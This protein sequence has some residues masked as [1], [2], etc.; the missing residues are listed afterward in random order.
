MAVDESK[1]NV[2]MQNLVHD[3]APSCMSTT[4]KASAFR[5]PKSQAMALA[6]DPFNLI[7]EARP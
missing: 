1:L 2:F 4:P 6:E 3:W 7:F 5:S